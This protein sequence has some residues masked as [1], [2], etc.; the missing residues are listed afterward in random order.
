MRILCL[1]FADAVEGMH[2][3][4][5]AEAVMSLDLINFVVIIEVEF[6]FPDSGYCVDLREREDVCFFFAVLFGCIIDF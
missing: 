3:F 5:G 2:V 6:L 1:C 4:D